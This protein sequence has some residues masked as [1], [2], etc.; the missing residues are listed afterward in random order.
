MN[1]GGAELAQQLHVIVGAVALVLRETVAGILLVIGDHHAI[2]SN[3]R[4]D[5][6]GRDTKALAIAA[7]DSRLRQLE[8]WYQAPVHEHVPPRE[9]ERGERPPTPPHPPPAAV[10]PT[11]LTHA[12][13]AHADP[14]RALA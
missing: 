9:P 8:S 12:R 10:D 2:A 6:R 5:R 11:H 7:D 4:D 13:D 14:D 1:R 3:L